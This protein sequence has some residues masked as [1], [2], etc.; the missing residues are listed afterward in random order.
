MG[1]RELQRIVLS[2]V[3]E[4]RMASAAAAGLL[5]VSAMQ[6]QRLMKTFQ[7]QGAPALR[8]KARGRP[9]KNRILD[10]VRDFALELIREHYGDFGPTLAR[11][12]LA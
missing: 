5:G 9:S 8:H 10:G 2:R 12:K 4:R 1:E 6:V 7:S 3:S 11:E